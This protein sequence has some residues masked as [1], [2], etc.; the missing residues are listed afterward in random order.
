MWAPVYSVID[1]TKKTQVPVYDLARGTIFD[2][3]TPLYRFQPNI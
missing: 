3:Y 1:L 2:E